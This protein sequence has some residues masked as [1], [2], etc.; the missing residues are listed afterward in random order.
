MAPS[1]PSLPYPPQN[2]LIIGNEVK[3]YEKVLTAISIGGN[4]RLGL[5][6]KDD[7]IRKPELPENLEN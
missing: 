3:F 6:T 1:L 2:H 7:K 5:M 4:F